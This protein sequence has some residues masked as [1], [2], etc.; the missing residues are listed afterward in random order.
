MTL[1]VTPTLA[2][3][4]LGFALLPPALSQ[5]EVHLSPAREGRASEVRLM[6][7]QPG[8]RAL[9]IDRTTVETEVRPDGLPAGRVV[10]VRDV[11]VHGEAR[12]PLPAE[13]FAAAAQLAVV[14]AG[15]AGSLSLAGALKLPN[16]STVL[17]QSSSAAQSRRV[18]VSEFMK[19]PAA[20]SDARGEWIEV[21]NPSLV[22]VD[23]EGWTLSDHSGAAT[24]LLN[25]GAGIIAPPR[26]FAV[27]ARNADPLLNGGV[28]ATAIFTGFS[29]GNGADQ[30]VLHD[31]NGSLVDEV[32]YLD[33]PTWPDRPGAS[34]SLSPRAWFTRHDDVATAWCEGESAM[35]A[36]DLGTPGTFN[37]TCWD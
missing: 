33:G 14:V 17:T 13:A 37:D 16:Q 31:W 9:L 11:D 28:T 23:M 1:T 20:V 30:I 6:A 29:L 5:A 36:G 34:V 3:L 26:G 2:R 19:D 18:I 32:A 27:L 15:P 22:A 12:F 25:G 8:A 35:P 7:A 21:Y 4:A 24:V 10:A